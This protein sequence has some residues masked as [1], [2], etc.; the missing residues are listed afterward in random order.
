MLDDKYKVEMIDMETLWA[1]PS[2]NCRGHIAPIDV[3]D[4]AKDIAAK[5][6][7]IPITVMPIVHEKYKYKVVAGH[8][9][10]MAFL[11]NK[12][13]QIPAYVRPDFDELGARR[14]NLRE[15]LHREDLNIKQE[16]HA[17]KYFLQ[18]KVGDRCVF[19]DKELA[20]EFGQSVGWI[21]VRKSLLNLPDDIQDEAA[22]GMINQD[23]IRI[24]AKIKK[25]EDR[26]A[27]LR[28]IKEK[29][30]RG[31]VVKLETT[32]PT[33]NPL[34]SKKRDPI[35]IKQIQ[36]ELY[37]LIGPG[38]VTRVLAWCRGEISTVALYNSIQDYCREEDIP[39]KMPAYINQA[40]VGI[41]P[42]KPEF[43]AD[44]VS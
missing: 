11:V 36:D 40:L 7:D 33:R 29:K 1:D 12:A 14:F 5:G 20:E 41:K 30:Q 13:T 2:F 22:A 43:V 10:H 44:V 15:N 42:A 35:E 8:R 21:Q 32:Q 6:L 37:D 28:K 17:L 34:K 38:L 18:Y 16:A 24:L 23:Q 25:T 3:I 9:R 26:Y 4:L 31:E 39:F 19:T 27:L